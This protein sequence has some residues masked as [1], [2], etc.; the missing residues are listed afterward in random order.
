MCA[1]GAARP[2][3]SG[4]KRLRAAQVSRPPCSARSISLLHKVSQVDVYKPSNRSCIYVCCTSC[5]Q[6][7]STIWV[8]LYAVFVVNRTANQKRRSI[9]MDA[10]IS[11]CMHR[12]LATGLYPFVDEGWSAAAFRPVLLPHGSSLLPP[13]AGESFLSRR[14]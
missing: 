9:E 6:P 8:Y 2:V 4:S 5:Y 14:I 13:L 11:A 12:W 10:M 3:A 7:D 1:G